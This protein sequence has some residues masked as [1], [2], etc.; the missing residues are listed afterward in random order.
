MGMGLEL[1]TMIVTKGKEMRKEENLFQ[2]QKDGYRLY[3]MHLPI[4]V[5]KTKHSD[6]SGFGRIEKMEWKD[7]KTT[8]VYRL[9]SLNS[10]N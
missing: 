2:L 5:K 8:I 4:D 3:P 7:E 6:P 10:T 9:I 1:N